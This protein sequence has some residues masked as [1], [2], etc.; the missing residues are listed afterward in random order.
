MCEKPVLLEKK[1]NIATITMNRP[2]TLNS[3]QPVLIDELVNALISVQ[4]DDSVKVAVLTGAGRAFCAGG[5]LTHIETID[6]PVQARDYIVKA[7]EIVSTIVNMEKP[8]IAMVNGV[9]AGAGFNIALA[10]DIIFCAKSVRFGQSFAKIGLIPD[11]GGTYFL[12]RAVGL[13]K[14]KELMFTGDLIDADTALKLGI[15]NK[16]IDDAELKETTYKFAEKLANGAPIAL[17]LIKKALNQSFSLNL[18]C[19]LELEA[20]LQC[21]CL[22]TQDNKEGINAFKE[23]RPPVFKGI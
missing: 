14:A 17:A 5:D 11:C 1:D 23:K 8:V 7:A 3:L 12:P 18:E 22:Q 20:S 19:A 15:V 2:Q 4:N 13:H 21:N 9:A 16:V 10:C 6:N